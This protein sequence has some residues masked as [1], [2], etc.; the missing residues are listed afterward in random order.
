MHNIKQFI[1]SVPPGVFPLLAAA[2]GLSAFQQKLHHWLS[3]QSGKLKMTISMIL[4]VLIVLLPHWIGILSG[5]KYLLGAYTTE[6]L[7]AMTIFYTFLIKESSQINE[8][9]SL[10]QIVIP[11]PPVAEPVPE[12]TVANF[13]SK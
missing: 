5:N 6:V 3:V 9:L 13:E 4:S 7:S 11:E 2:L 12:E 8:D 1:E 10:D